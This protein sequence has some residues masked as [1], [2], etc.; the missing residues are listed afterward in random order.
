MGLGLTIYAAALILCSF[1]NAYWQI[2]LL[3][4]VMSGIGIG[5]NVRPY[6]YLTTN[7][8]LWLQCM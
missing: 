7:H 6:T 1:F 8:S 5:I 2:F 3:Y 4:G